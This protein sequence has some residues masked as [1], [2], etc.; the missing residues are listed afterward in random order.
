MTAL[1]GFP[2]VAS[3]D[4]ERTLISSDKMETVKSPCGIGE[5]IC[6]DGWSLVRRKF[7][8]DG[9]KEQMELGGSGKDAGD[10]LLGAATRCDRVIRCFLSGDASSAHGPSGVGCI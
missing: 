9:E 1:R 5:L 4:M 3:L 7:L 6:G 8:S 2:P 10:T